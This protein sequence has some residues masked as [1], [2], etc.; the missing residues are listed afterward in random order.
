MGKRKTTLRI[1]TMTCG[2]TKSINYLKA[3]TDGKDVY[4][5]LCNCNWQPVSISVFSKEEM[6]FGCPTWEVLFNHIIG[7]RVFDDNDTVINTFDNRNIK[8]KQE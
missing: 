7:A 6:T 1:A 4:I 8:E 2:A 3:S 5:D